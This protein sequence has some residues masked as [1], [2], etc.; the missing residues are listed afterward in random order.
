MLAVCAAVVPACFNCCAALSAA[1]DHAL[2]L[3]L[4]V[5]DVAEVDRHQRRHGD[6]G[7]QQHHQHAD[8]AALPG[9]RPADHC[10]VAG[11]VPLELAA[12]PRRPLDEVW[13][14]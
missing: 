4:A 11:S 13:P 12:E 5:E 2:Q 7:D 6:G 9:T 1:V 3:A 14:L 10:A 8:G